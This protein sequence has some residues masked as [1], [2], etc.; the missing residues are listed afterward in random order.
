MLLV[1]ITS[2]VGHHF[3]DHRL[4]PFPDE[5]PYVS[6]LVPLNT[7]MEP[8][9]WC[10]SFSRGLFQVYTTETPRCLPHHKRDT[11][12]LI[13]RLLRAR[14]IYDLPRKKYHHLT[15][16]VRFLFGFGSLC[17]I[18][19]LGALS[20]ICFLDRTTSG[21]VFCWAYGKS[22]PIPQRKK[23]HLG[24][25]DSFRQNPPPNL[26][27][28]LDFVGWWLKWIKQNITQDECVYISNLPLSIHPGS[29][30]LYLIYLLLSGIFGCEIC[31]VNY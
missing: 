14:D 1:K 13:S 20:F 7:N 19:P 11:S 6:V 21:I 22:P 4:L 18:S 2:L 8:N 28:L 29:V 9:T 25:A 12:P 31:Q 5:S 23:E 3:G 16:C 26:F 27:F 30:E 15:S 17:S 10:C 24:D